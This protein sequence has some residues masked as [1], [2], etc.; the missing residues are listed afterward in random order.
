MRWTSI[1]ALLPIVALAHPAAAGTIR[2]RVHLPPAPRAAE[3]ANAYPGNAHAMPGMHA[4]PRGL[5]ADAVV[6]VERIPAAAESALARAAAGAAAPQLAQ[7]DQAFVPR[8]LAVATGGAVDF[9]NQDPIYHNVFSLSSVRRFDLGKYPKGSSRRVTFPRAGLVNVY[10]DIHA[11]MEAFILVLPNH[12]FTRPSPAG[13]FALPEL[14]AG[15]YELRVWHPDFGTTSTTVDVPAT[16][17][18]VV[19]AGW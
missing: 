3:A 4:P 16:G 8:V 9:P 10:C 15:R 7:K 19:E 2:G 1:A 18:A 5:P 6:S 17:D 12:A 11:S 13:G 14:P